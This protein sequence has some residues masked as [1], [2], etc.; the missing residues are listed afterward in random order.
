MEGGLVGKIKISNIENSE[1]LFDYLYGV[2]ESFASYMKMTLNTTKLK[3]LLN[4]I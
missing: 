1:E 2:S 4:L 3:I